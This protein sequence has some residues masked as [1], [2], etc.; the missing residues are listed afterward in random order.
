MKVHWHPKGVRWYMTDK[1][2]VLG[3]TTQITLLYFSNPQHDYISELFD[4]KG[5]R[6]REKR[7]KERWNKKGRKRGREG[8]RKKDEFKIPFLETL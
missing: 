3:I 4:H 8:K 1:H 2:Q 5:K 6:K 7:E